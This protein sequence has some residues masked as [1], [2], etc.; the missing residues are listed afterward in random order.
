MDESFT[1][2]MLQVD[3]SVEG[4]MSAPELDNVSTSK[5]YLRE[6]LSLLSA[7]LPPKKRWATHFPHKWK[8]TS[9]LLCPAV[10][11]FNVVGGEV[12]VRIETHIQ[13]PDTMFH[14]T[15]TLCNVCQCICHMSLRPLISF[16]S[17]NLL[18]LLHNYA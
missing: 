3:N 6:V 5:Y 7:L 2:H 10:F 13:I 1:K 4:R 12:M 15:K 18:Y 14:P 16:A 8:W 9:P 11:S 17:T